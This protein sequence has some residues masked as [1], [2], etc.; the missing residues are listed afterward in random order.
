MHRAL[1]DADHAR[2]PALDQSHVDIAYPISQAVA[3]MHAA[4]RILLAQDR[5]APFR[6]LDV[7]CGGGTKLLAAASMFHQVCGL[8]LDPIYLEQ[9]RRLLALA[10]QGRCQVEAG[11]ALTYDGYGRFDVIYLYEPI[12]EAEPELALERRIFAQCRPGCVVIAPHPPFEMRFA[13]HGLSRLTDKL[14]VAGIAPQ[15]AEHLLRRTGHIG[16]DALSPEP[17]PTDNR[18]GWLM[19]VATA[20]RR[21][22]HSFG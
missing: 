4:Q 16:P 18:L 12:R 3:L 10:R 22:G 2:D 8:E 15:A 21:L 9:A 20:F 1:G 11:D 5:P 19:P 13:G 6:F 17:G 14:Y 7:G